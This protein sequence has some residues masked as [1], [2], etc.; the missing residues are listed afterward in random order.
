MDPQPA[1]AAQV[2]ATEPQPPQL[3]LQQRVLQH[4]G[5]QQRILGIRILQHLGLQQLLQPV[6]QPVLQ[7]DA[8]GAAHVGAQETAAGAAQ[9]TG[10]GAQQPWS[11]TAC[12]AA[13]QQNRTAAVKVVHFIM[14]F[15]WKDVGHSGTE[16][17]PEIP[18]A[19]CVLPSGCTASGHQIRLRR[20]IFCT[21]FSSRAFG[22]HDGKPGTVIDFK[23][24]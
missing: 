17:N 3:L 20:G 10:A 5:L 19:I 9:L 7:H 24:R 22:K 1:G 23:P 18:T 12:V 13:A 21:Y 15:S 6:L 14:G 8:T 2:G 16:A 11:A 4:L